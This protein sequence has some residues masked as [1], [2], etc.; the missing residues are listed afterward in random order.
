MTYARAFSLGLVLALFSL[1]CGGGGG[2]VV[3]PAVDGSGRIG[4]AGGSVRLGDRAGVS[5]PAGALT[6]SVVI[7]ISPTAVPQALAERNAIGQAYRF[8]PEG[9]RFSAP[10]QVFVFVATAAL[11]GVPIERVTLLSTG[12]AGG[13]AVEEL[14]GIAAV[15][16]AGGFEIQ[17]RTDHFSVIVPAVR[18]DP[19]VAGAGP[20]LT[21]TVG[22][23]VTIHG[24]GS[25]PEGGSVSFAWSFESRPAGSAAVLQDPDTA[26]AWFVPDVAGA[27]VVRLTVTDDR[28][29]TATDTVT[30]PVSPATPGPVADAGPDRLA[31]TGQTVELDAGGSTGS[32]LAFAWRIVTSPVTPFPP[33]TGAS[34]VRASFVPPAPGAYVVELL[35]TN[36]EGTD[37][38]TVRIDVVQP[39]RAPTGSIL[40]PGAVF[41][42]A[43][44]TAQVQ[45][46][47]LDGDPL[48]FSWDVFDPAGG[49]V[50]LGGS[51]SS[52][53]FQAASIGEYTVVVTID[54]AQARTTISAAVLSNARVAGDYDVTIEA[55]PTN[56][57][58][59][60][61][62]AEGTLPVQ[63]P[64]PDV[65]ILDLEG[66]SEQFVGK[67][68]GTLAG[69]RFTYS[70]PIT[71]VTD[72]GPPR[73]TTTV[74]GTISGTISDGGEM[75]L[76]AEI[77]VL[78][79]CR[80]GATITGT[81]Q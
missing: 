32:G 24:S 19:P 46:Q 15:P 60:K 27:Y 63:Q 30:I 54:D 8:E 7:G 41:V 29:A 1:A 65:V 53:Q 47:D 58:R 25:D 6:S 64:S 26:T 78:G 39:N 69:E 55:D 20:D 31:E 75:D 61:T 2:G 23:T 66:A 68:T 34:S 51:G 76:V 70:G 59:E 40:A 12:G 56:C 74:S 52:V 81:R 36:A 13:A 9:Q 49:A 38:D 45:A 43:G 80:I 21:G 14:A 71:V 37:T 44:V 50:V 48:T 11:Q 77:N 57:G 3:E 4:P 10:V 42:G 22:K 16:V 5:I 28:G 18:N 35:V 67:A 79:F 17:G 62:T 73:Q 72:P 33:I